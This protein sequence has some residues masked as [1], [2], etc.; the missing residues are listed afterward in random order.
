MPVPKSRPADRFNV[1][2]SSLANNLSL[3]ISHLFYV[4]VETDESYIVTIYYLNVALCLYPLKHQN[5]SLNSIYFR[6]THY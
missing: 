1:Q 3:P 5:K 6:D 2:F 4:A